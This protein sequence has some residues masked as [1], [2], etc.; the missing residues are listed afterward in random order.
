MASRGGVD[1][2]ERRLRPIYG[3]IRSLCCGCYDN[4]DKYESSH[5]NRN[6]VCRISID[7][8]PLQ[9]ALTGH[10]QSRLSDPCAHGHGH[11][12]YSRLSV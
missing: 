12:S 10:F 8:W 3:S 5:I 6:N 4:S 9:R 1:V 2:S 7:V 11:A